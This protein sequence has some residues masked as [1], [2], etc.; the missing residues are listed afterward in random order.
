MSQDHE[1]LWSRSLFPIPRHYYI[2]C[3]FISHVWLTNMS[4]CYIRSEVGGDLVVSCRRSIIIKM[5]VG[6][7]RLLNLLTTF[8]FLYT[9]E[10][11]H[12]K[13]RLNKLRSRYNRHAHLHTHTHTHPW[14][15][16]WWQILVENISSGW[17]EIR[18]MISRR[19]KKTNQNH[20]PL[21]KPFTPISRS[22]IFFL[23]DLFS[24][25][26]Q[27]Y[28]WLYYNSWKNK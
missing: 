20:S 7:C 16:I 23:L 8:L 13:S 21:N 17:P 5:Y 26:R 9:C 2:Y 6:F 24:G 14:A 18:M 15:Y 27:T 25:R 22:I 12:R 1:I 4:L 19:K 11:T 3:C 28:I 10:Q